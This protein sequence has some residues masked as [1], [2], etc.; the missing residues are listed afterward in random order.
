M[1]LAVERGGMI[2]GARQPTEGRV[3]QWIRVALR[4][5]EEW[6]APVLGLGIRLFL[7]SVFFQAGLTK[8]ASWSSTL[9]LFESE[10]RVP[11]LP[12]EVAAYL[13][14]GVE[15]GFP[16]LLVLGLGSRFAAAVL[17]VFNVVAV[18]SYP[19]LSEVGLKDHQYWGLLL[20]VPLFYGP[21]RLSLDH[22]IR[23]RFLG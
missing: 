14:T 11:L 15:L 4:V 7:A 16:V 6:F 20:L 9:A 23:R 1:E 8:F 19:D 13:G 12:P 18:V 17:F 22:L 21:G 3:K 5:A 2:A 10:Y